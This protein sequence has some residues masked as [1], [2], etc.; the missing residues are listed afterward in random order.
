MKLHQRQAVARINIQVRPNVFGNNNLPL[1]QHLSIIN[2][3]NFHH[4]APP[5][6]PPP[7]APHTP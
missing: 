2:Y 6:L 4:V 1:W 3:R 7:T 5:P